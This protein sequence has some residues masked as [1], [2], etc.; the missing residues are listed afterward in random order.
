MACRDRGIDKAA[1]KAPTLQAIIYFRPLLS[2][3]SHTP[4][5]MVAAAAIYDRHSKKN[6]ARFHLSW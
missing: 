2:T 6:D 3:N 5:A 4:T 1:K